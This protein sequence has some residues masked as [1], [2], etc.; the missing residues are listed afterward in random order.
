[1]LNE[2]ENVILLASRRG[3]VGACQNHDK[4]VSNSEKNVPTISKRLQ[5]CSQKRVRKTKIM[6][7]DVREG[8]DR[9]GRVREGFLQPNARLA[10]REFL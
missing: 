2:F 3:N 1:M 5:I 10:W 4:F 8:R 6:L 7:A 9:E